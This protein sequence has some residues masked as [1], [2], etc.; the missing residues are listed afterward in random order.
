M[1]GAGEGVTPGRPPALFP[2]FAGIETLPGV[3]PRAAESFAQMGITR[4]RDLILTLPH[5]GI[6]R[7]PIARL[8]DAQPPEIITV[9][10]TVQRHVPPTAKGRPWRVQ[11]SDGVSDL[12]L[13][14]FHPRRD[15]IEGQLPVG[16]RRTVSGKVE[17]F[18]G[19]AQM[20]HPDHIGPE[21]TPLP[22]EFE[23]VYPL[24]GRLTQGVVQ[25][26]VRAALTRLPEVGEW[27]VRLVVSFI[28]MPGPADLCNEGDVDHLVR[29]FLLPGID[30]T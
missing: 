6:R 10:V 23:P 14:F 5:S 7:R 16:Q 13:V 15:W 28:L 9:T 1:A 11:C 29:T 17:L 21:G 3:G 8:S 24:S 20:V 26:A 25:K 30:G 19:M 12:Q 4:P 27:I 18:D 2:L 22:P